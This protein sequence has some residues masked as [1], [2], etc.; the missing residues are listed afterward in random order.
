M[1]LTK[2]LTIVV[3]LT[4]IVLFASDKK[5]DGNTYEINQCLKARM[6]Q[7]DNQLDKVQNHN[8]LDFKKSRNLTCTDI[9]STYEGGSY[10]SVKYGNCVISLD[11]WYL[12][13]I[14]V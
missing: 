12:N 2:S 7:L 1:K 6:G 10:L 3:M 14:K 8:T 13:Q 11:R 9:S 4:P 5:C